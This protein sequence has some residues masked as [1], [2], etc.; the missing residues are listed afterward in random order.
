MKNTWMIFILVVGVFAFVHFAGQYNI[1]DSDVT[2]IVVDVPKKELGKK[3]VEVDE[4]IL[5]D[6]C[7]DLRYFDCWACHYPGSYDG[8]E[9]GLYPFA[10]NY[11][12]IFDHP[13]SP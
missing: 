12:E 5:S 1:Q 2:N 9:E 4:K 13:K 6:V 10:K 7:E 8:L 3:F 11:C